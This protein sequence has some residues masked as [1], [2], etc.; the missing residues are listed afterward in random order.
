MA[1]GSLSSRYTS[2][3]TKELPSRYG[4]AIL[5]DEQYDVDVH[6]DCWKDSEATSAGHVRRVP[7]DK[8]VKRRTG[9]A[10]TYDRTVVDRLR[11]IRLK[12]EVATKAGTIEQIF[13][14]LVG[15]AE[16]SVNLVYTDRD[17]EDHDAALD[18][19]HDASDD[20]P[21]FRQGVHAWT[22]VEFKIPEEDMQ[23]GGW[24]IFEDDLGEL[25]YENVLGR[26]SIRFESEKDM[27][28]DINLVVPD[29]ADG[30]CY[31]DS[32]TITVEGLPTIWDGAQSEF[33]PDSDS[34]LGQPKD[35]NG[36]GDTEADAGLDGDG[37]SSMGGH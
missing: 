14:P 11:F 20:N 16:F 23:N 29:P 15:R 22:G 27:R 1:I 28:V 33:T 35:N 12:G 13:N 6:L 5:Q 3:K 31:L 19:N 18:D 32:K 9:D 7:I 8:K 17:F 26:L 25:R 36:R 2:I 21:M 37:D 10:G 24:T 30:H 34:G 4:Y